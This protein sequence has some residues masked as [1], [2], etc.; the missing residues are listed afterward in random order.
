MY[1]A[2][3]RSETDLQW[4][5]VYGGCY[6]LAAIAVYALLKIINSLDPVTMTEALTNFSIWSLIFIL[7]FLLLIL[8]LRGYLYIGE[9]YYMPALTWST[10]VFIWSIIAISVIIIFDVFLIVAQAHE[11]AEAVVSGLIVWIAV[12]YMLAPL[13]IGIAL[14]PL[15]REF[16]V[17]ALYPL[18]VMLVVLA[19]YAYGFIAEALG[20]YP[21]T[22]LGMMVWM[23]IPEALF[24]IASIFVFR[25]AAGETKRR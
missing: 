20:F 15:R 3:M 2:Y 16:G 6:M 8:T 11:A 19:Y 21:P 12:F 4:A 23:P 18:V 9:K 7:P 10:R 5:A 14:Y 13:S 22:F 1:T 17:V 25:A 24:V